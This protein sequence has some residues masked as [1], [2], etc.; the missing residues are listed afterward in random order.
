MSLSSRREL[1]QQVGPRYRSGSRREKSR[2]LNEFVAA[3][4]YDRKYAIKV[5]RSVATSPRASGPRPQRT[6]RPK[7]GSDVSHALLSLWKVSRGLCARRLHPHIPDLIDALERHKELPLLPGV[8]LQ[9]LQ[10]SRSTVERMLAAQKRS[11]GTGI[12]TTSPG[13]LLRHQIPIHTFA[14]WQEAQPGFMEIDLVAHCGES[15]RGTFV[16]TLTMTDVATGWTEC[17]AVP[18]KGQ[19]AVLQALETIRSHLPFPLRGID[20]D[21]GSEFINHAL[22][23]FC[24]SHG[25]RFT[26]GRPYKKNDQCHV[27]QKNGAVVRI[28]VGYGRYEG[29][30]AVRCINRLYW[31]HR[32]FLNYLAPSMKLTNKVRHGARVTKTYDTAKTPYRRLIGYDILD[33]EAQDEM[34]RMYLSLNPA[35]INRRIDERE[36]DLRKHTV[37]EYDPQDMVEPVAKTT[38]KGRLPKNLFN[39]NSK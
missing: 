22:A 29:D 37:K 9:L 3:T 11:L 8:R 4:E 26:R 1:V 21:N 5:L 28:L 23:A 35:K 16:F 17:M 10:I 27:E 13:T 30:E 6:R 31:T 36:H 24:T 25:I 33:Q 15:A 39:V 34:S 2:I 38:V 18:N 20:S 32:F 14:D 7:Y 12:S 19:L